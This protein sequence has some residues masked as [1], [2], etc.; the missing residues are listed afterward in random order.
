MENLIRH[1]DGSVTTKVTRA[2]VRWGA[3]GDVTHSSRTT[4]HGRL[5]RGMVRGMARR[6]VPAL[7]VLSVRLRVSFVLVERLLHGAVV[8]I[9]RQP[10]VRVRP[11]PP[12]VSRTNDGMTECVEFLWSGNRWRLPRSRSVTT[13][14]IVIS[15]NN[16]KSPNLAQ[17]LSRLSWRP[18][19]QISKFGVYCSAG[20]SRAIPGRGI[21]RGRLSRRLPIIW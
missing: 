7:R 10:W 2:D 18:T 13:G 21:A 9:I 11:A 12:A 4:G 15:S 16:F 14:N 5:R 6:I 3:L 8:L 17:L 20:S 19:R 1:R